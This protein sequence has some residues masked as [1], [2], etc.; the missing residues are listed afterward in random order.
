[1]N[2]HSTSRSNGR[3]LRVV[4]L[5]TANV[6]ALAILASLMRQH[7]AS[8]APSP[9]ANQPA[10]QSATSSGTPIEAPIDTQRDAVE[11]LAQ[12]APQSAER[13][14]AVVLDTHVQP[15][16]TPISRERLAAL[17]NAL[18]REIGATLER[19]S[20]ETGG[21][22][23]TR[24][25]TVALH[26]RPLGSNADGG[27]GLDS[28]RAMR[29]ASNLKLVTTAA[30][31]VLLGPDWKFD[32]RAEASGPIA[33]G[34][35]NGDLV[36]RASGDPLYQ[37]GANGRVSELFAP[38]I[39][40]LV[41]SGVHEVRGDLVLDELSFADPAP[42]PA[43]P[44]ANQHWEEFCA[45][46]AGFTVNR[47]CLTV[48]VSPSG[49]GSPA[50]VAI[51]PRGLDLAPS[52]DVQTIAKGPLNV[53]LGVRESKL[54]V[55]GSIP[56]GSEP[57][58]GACSHPNP[59]SLFGAVLES[60]LARNG[61]KLDGTVRRERGAK[62]GAVIA[63]LT[64]PLA[65][66]LAAINTDSTNGVADQ[67]Y[68][69]TALA[70]RGE[71]TRRAGAEATALALAKLGVSSEGL[72]Q[73]DGS[74]LSRD[75]RVSARQM[76][77]LV[78]AVLSHDPRTATLFLDSLA[79]AGESGTLDDRLKNSPARGRIHAKTGFISGTS[80][81]CGV[82]EAND[83]ARFVFSILVDYPGIEGLNTRYWKPLE[84]KLCEL[85]VEA[86][87]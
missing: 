82:A 50:S 47:G 35:L 64:S 51:E 21:K 6:A 45:L 71:A 67:V 57:W 15:T 34:V 36:L 81:L 13:S 75:D 55:A 39:A 19:V 44:A 23:S 76:T 33:N 38:F 54:I 16:A 69:A 74:G 42:G 83:G 65:D 41:K 40:E 56:R 84:N 1:M 87:S 29:P 58:T 46:A 12:P 52:V 11:R 85:M 86:G 80:A 3:A 77:A 31:L 59:V 10:T 60:E 27:V 8:A 18:R 78:C 28:D 37:R 79:T 4:L 63:H 70:V 53:R 25:T 22:A 48:T 43:W 5:V 62:G 2:T 32:T 49:V 66:C 9:L 30:A 73:V 20:K 68:F 61:I 7:A 24:N 14:R 26:V 17:E 72:V